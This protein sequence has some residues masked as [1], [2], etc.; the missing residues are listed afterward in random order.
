VST[1]QSLFFFLRVFL[2]ALRTLRVSL[3]PKTRLAQSPH[4]NPRNPHHPSSS[5]LGPLSSLAVKNLPPFSFASLN[6]LRAFAVNLNPIKNHQSKFSTHQSLFFFLRVFLR[7][8]R[9]LRVSLHPKTSLKLLAG[10]SEK[11][12]A[13]LTNRANLFEEVK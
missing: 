3:H 2:R 8:L 1:H 11:R 5:N 12:T 6:D 7:A 9:T 10:A 13:N 4:Q